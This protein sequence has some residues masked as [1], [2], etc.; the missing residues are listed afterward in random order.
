[1]KYHKIIWGLETIADIQLKI[2]NI[3]K[4]AD[5]ANSQLADIETGLL[6]IGETHKT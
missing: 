1:M 5:I 3:I 4:L 2:Q 6:Q